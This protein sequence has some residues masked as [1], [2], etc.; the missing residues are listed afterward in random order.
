MQDA[1]ASEW[2][3][4]R[5]MKLLQILALTSLNLLVAA[6]TW[7]QETETCPNREGWKPPPSEFRRILNAHANY[8]KTWIEGADKHDFRGPPKSAQAPRTGRANLC[9][10]NLK[11]L[12]LSGL[13]LA[14]AQLSGADLA[15]ADLTNT[16][17][18]S[19]EL[20]GANLNGA[21]LIGA[22]LNNAVLERARLNRALL[23]P[24]HPNEARRGDVIDRNRAAKLSNSDLSW[25][26]LSG[27]DLRG[28]DLSGAS[29]FGADLS[30]AVLIFA[31]LDSADL[32]T[33]RLQRADLTKASVTAAHLAD[34]D[35]TD[36]RYAPVS[37]D[38]D[39][40]VGGIQGLATVVFDSG[41]ET[42]LVQLRG[43]LQKAGLR[44]LERQATYAIETNK[45]R[46]AFLD[47]DDFGSTLE[48]FFRWAAFDWTTR[49]GM[50]PARALKFIFWVWLVLTLVY[51]YVIHFAPKESTAGIYQVWPSERIET[52]G[53]KAS[54]S[55]SSKVTRLQEAPLRALVYAAYF[56]LLSAFHI[57]WRDL[58]VGNWITRIQPREYVLRATGWVRAVS[59]VQSLLSVYLLAMWALTYFGRPFQ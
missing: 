49:Y 4:A 21:K 15:G 43:L 20:T 37:P 31:Q 57:G 59:G 11:D 47:G 54:L 41:M 35:L 42:G 53:N 22:K 13:N 3:E 23:G 46:N 2:A 56:S 19:A 17:L 18:R 40:F 55:E 30:G 26:Q 10:A 5:P 45:T 39:S 1:C 52:E 14:G 33:A 36:A 58:N 27:A 44:E 50:Y 29:L 24:N 34:A 38:C 8:T 32:N 9:N 16:D 48:A 51:F 28:A 7:A 25:A 6:T 12:S